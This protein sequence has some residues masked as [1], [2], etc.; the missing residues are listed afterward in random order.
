[1]LAW[2]GTFDIGGSGRKTTDRLVRIA[3]VSTA[4]RPLC[5]CD[6]DDVEL[7]SAR[8]NEACGIAGLL[9]FGATTFQG[10]LEGPRNAVFERMEVIIA[11][12]RHHSLR[13]LRESQIKTA[14]FRNWSF[15]V[16]P[17]SS[18]AQTNRREDASFI[19][20]LAQRLRG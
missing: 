10:I 12:E 20:S 15:G 17:G 14:R 18:G 4:S 6:L 1:M 19:L 13:V 2:Q 9:L 5:R 8:N 7:R 11:D 3:Y 16:L